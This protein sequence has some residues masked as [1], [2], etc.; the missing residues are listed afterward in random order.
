[1]ATSWPVLFQHLAV[2]RGFLRRLAVV[3]LAWAKTHSFALDALAHHRQPS[4]G[5]AT[6]QH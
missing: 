3:E 1:M 6:P 4:G 2:R 5:C